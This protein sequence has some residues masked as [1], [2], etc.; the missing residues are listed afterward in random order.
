MGTPNGSRMEPKRT[1]NGSRTDP[2]RTPIGPSVHDSLHWK[3][4]DPN[5]R[6]CAD[7][8]LVLKMHFQRHSFNPSRS[9]AASKTKQKDTESIQTSFHHGEFL[10]HTD[11]AAK[12]AAS[13]AAPVAATMKMVVEQWQQQNQ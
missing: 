7:A 1:P 10:I 3:W 2:E 6:K 8:R 4:P 13:A 5:P 12:A 11:A 9:Q